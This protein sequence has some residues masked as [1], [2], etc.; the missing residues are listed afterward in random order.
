MPEIKR[1]QGETFEAFF[2]RFTK[3][4]QQSGRML[5]AKKIKYYVKEPSRNERRKSALMR[6]KKKAEL[7]YLKKIGKIDETDRFVRFRFK[8]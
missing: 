3:A 4:I 5:Q 6:N 8:K 1:K 7:E 2:R